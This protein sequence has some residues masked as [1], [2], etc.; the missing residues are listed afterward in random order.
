MRL[1]IS[2]AGNAFTAEAQRAILA[3]LVRAAPGR[4]ARLNPHRQFQRDAAART[5]GAPATAGNPQSQTADTYALGGT[6]TDHA[7]RSGS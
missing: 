5:S 2:A 7:V 6:R 4:P 1:A 3:L